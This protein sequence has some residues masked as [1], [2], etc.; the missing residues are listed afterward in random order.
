VGCMSMFFSKG[1]CCEGPTSR[2]SVMGHSL[3]SMQDSTNAPLFSS[4]P[5]GL[6]E[7]PQSLHRVSTVHIYLRFED[8]RIR[9]LYFVGS[10]GI[11]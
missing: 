2:S 10:S 5:Q 8:L 4:L 11:P 6:T 1:S 9:Y 3:S 7:S